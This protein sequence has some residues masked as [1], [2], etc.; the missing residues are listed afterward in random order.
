LFFT[1]EAAAHH[2]FQAEY[3]RNQPIT[4][5]GVVTKVE[6]QN[7]HVYYYVDVRDAAGKVANWAI[8]VGA[9]NGL[10]RA[11]WRKDSLKPGDQV[12]V[13]AYLAKK[14]GNHANGRSVT[15][16]NGQRVFSG[17]NDG[18]PGGE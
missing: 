11:G 16:P 14:G 12:A 6:W 4:L 10:Y 7:P 15:L 1:H 13:E 17:Q 9:P 3:D 18:G 8:E 5:K 2:S